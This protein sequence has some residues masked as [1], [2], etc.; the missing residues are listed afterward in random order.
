MNKDKFN[1]VIDFA[2]EREKEAVQFYADLQKQVKFQAQKEML[3]E[4]EDM[5]KEGLRNEIRNLQQLLE[6][7]EKMVNE[8]E[9]KLKP[10]Y[11]DGAA[12]GV[13]WEGIERRFKRQAHLPPT[14]G[15]GDR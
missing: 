6:D 9:T 2:V 13:Y 11:K 5:E 1:E 12:E 14:Q 15:I 8:L 3:K 10:H 7:K 4:L